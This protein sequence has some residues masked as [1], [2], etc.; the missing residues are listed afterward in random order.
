MTNFDK[1]KQD[2]IDIINNMK[3]EEFYDLKD[4]IGT[5][6][7]GNVYGGKCIKLPESILT[8]AKCKKKYG[9]KCGDDASDGMCLK[10]FIDYCNEEYKE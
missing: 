3:V 5:Y 4:D 1:M 2:L 8:C 9:G 6:L 10:H 7:V